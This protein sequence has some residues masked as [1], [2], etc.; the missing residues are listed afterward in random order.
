MSD[1]AVTAWVC[2]PTY[3]ERENASAMVSAARN[4]LNEARVDGHVLVIDDASPDGTGDIV[5]EMAAADPRIHL[6]RRASKQ[7][8]GPAYRDGFKLAL[9]EGADLIVEMDC[10]FSHDPADIPRLITAAQTADVVLGSRYTRGGHVANWSGLRRTISRG[11]CIYA[12]TILRVPVSDLTGGFKCF[13]RQVLETIPLD[14][15]T[16]Q[17]YGFQVEMTYRA[18]KE[19]FTVKEIPITF[20][21]RTRGTSKMSGHIVTEAAVL[22]PKL[23]WRLRGSQPASRT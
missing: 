8:I 15:V 21:D 14:E 16:G 9:S 10:D 17:G 1:P 20:T 2:I 13:R 22:V 11:G 7:G 6:L 23:K 5:A 18:L 19:G 12:K 4:A 3:D